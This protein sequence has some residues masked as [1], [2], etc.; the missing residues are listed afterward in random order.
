M[1]LSDDLDLCRLEVK[2]KSPGLPRPSQ[3][4]ER[5]QDAQGSQK[6][7]GGLRTRKVQGLQ[8]LMVFPGLPHLRQFSGLRQLKIY[9][10][11]GKPENFCRFQ[12]GLKMAEF[13]ECDA[14]LTGVNNRPRW[15]SHGSRAIIREPSLCQ[16]MAALIGS[17]GLCDPVV[18]VTWEYQLGLEHEP[19]PDI[20]SEVLV[21]QGV[22]QRPAPLAR[23]ASLAGGMYPDQPWMAIHGIQI[24]MVKPQCPFGP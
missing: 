7:E 19:G 13:P 17:K 8:S 24:N 16:R 12:L 5:T 2:H 10:I 20:S 15:A 9:I 18:L 22:V 14:Q 1:S 23:R 3:E 4:P 6:G 21:C 11:K